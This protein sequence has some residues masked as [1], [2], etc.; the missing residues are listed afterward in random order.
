MVPKP[1]GT[2]GLLGSGGGAGIVNARGTLGLLGSG[3]GAGIV[4][5]R[6]TL[7]LF[8]FGGGAGIVWTT[9]TLKGLSEKIAFVVIEFPA[10]Q[11]LIDAINIVADLNKVFTIFS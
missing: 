7:G 2:L 1:S 3:G 4:N 5:P 6:G 9:G 11:V 10:K 8:G